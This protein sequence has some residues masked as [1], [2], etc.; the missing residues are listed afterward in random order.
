M[1]IKQAFETLEIQRTTSLEEIKESYRDLLHVWHPDRHTDSPRRQ[2][3][4]EQK[5][6]DITEAYQLIVKTHSSPQ[7]T[8]VSAPNP[9]NRYKPPGDAPDPYSTAKD[10]APNN[11]FQ[12][13]EEPVNE[14]AFFNEV[15][16]ACEQNQQ[17]W[18]KKGFDVNWH[19]QRRSRLLENHYWNNMNRIATRYY[20]KFGG[21]HWDFFSPL[22]VHHVKF[23][24][25]QGVCILKMS[26]FEVNTYAALEKPSFLGLSRKWTKQEKTR[27]SEIKAYTMMMRIL[28]DHK[29]EIQRDHERNV[30]FRFAW[31]FSSDQS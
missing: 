1:N 31:N 18:F 26:D 7:F 6:R 14:E 25:T 16:K 12:F 21:R 5:T 9:E 27:E 8:S 30:R 24:E 10:R 13:A 19:L 20:I 29:V 17:K 4:A 11:H 3:K 23:L 15:L 22:F 28:F 2:A